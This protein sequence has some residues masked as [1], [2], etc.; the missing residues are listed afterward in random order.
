LVRGTDE[1]AQRLVEQG[2]EADTLP[3]QPVRVTGTS[4]TFED[5]VGAQE[6]ATL[7]PAAGRTA[8]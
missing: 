1:H 6:T 7:E 2:I 3:E 4:F 5:A 8:Y